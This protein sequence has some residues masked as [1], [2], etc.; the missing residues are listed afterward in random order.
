MQE[1]MWSFFKI[2][3]IFLHECYI[4][5]CIF[6]RFYW[7]FSILVRVLGYTNPRESIYTGGIPFICSECEFRCLLWNILNWFYYSSLFKFNS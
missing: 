5:K 1:N 4:N 3:Y 7:I 6:I 2:D